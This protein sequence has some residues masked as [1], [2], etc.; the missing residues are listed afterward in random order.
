MRMSKLR[1][2]EYHYGKASEIHPQNAVLLGCLG[3]VRVG[4][5]LACYG[6]ELMGISCLVFRW[7]ND[8][9]T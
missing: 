4:H 5:V 2:A 1:L 8:E 9:A 6:R 7:R 3:M